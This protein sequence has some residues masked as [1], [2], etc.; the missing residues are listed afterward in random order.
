MAHNVAALRVSLLLRTAVRCVM[1]HFNGTLNL[2]VAED[3]F[4]V[5]KCARVEGAI[6]HAVDCV[7]RN[8]N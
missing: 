4:V 2:L 7:L 6:T 3:D 5:V 1:I 8:C